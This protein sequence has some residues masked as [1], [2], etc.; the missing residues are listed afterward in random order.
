MYILRRRIYKG[1]DT[2]LLG[3]SVAS[4]PENFGIHFIRTA[5]HYH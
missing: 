2:I 4:G 1:M 5:S 3:F